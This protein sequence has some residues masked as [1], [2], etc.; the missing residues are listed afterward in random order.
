MGL[1]GWCGSVI[2]IGIRVARTADTNGSLLASTRANSVSKRNAFLE[3]RHVSVALN[4][5]L[6]SAGHAADVADHNMDQPRLAR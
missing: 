2:S 3:V 6:A 4:A 5:T 1:S